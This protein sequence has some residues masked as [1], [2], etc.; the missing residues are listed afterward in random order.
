MKRRIREKKR[1]RNREK[2]TKKDTERRRVR[3]TEGERKK[4]EPGGRG[5]NP[6]TNK[7]KAIRS[8][9]TLCQS[10]NFERRKYIR[11]REE[12]LPKTRM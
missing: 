12:Y 8:R 1:D 10:R 2:E 3:E 5:E 4:T 9:S 7:L 11:N 6:T